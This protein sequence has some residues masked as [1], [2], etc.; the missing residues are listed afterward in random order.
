MKRNDSCFLGRGVEV[1]KLKDSVGIGTN[2]KKAVISEQL[3]EISMQIVLYVGDAREKVNQAL[4]YALDRNYQEAYKVFYSANKDIT[5]AFE[6]EK[7]EFVSEFQ[8]AQTRDGNFYEAVTNML[9][10]V[11]KDYQNVEKIIPFL[12]KSEQY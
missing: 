10:T 5:S 1:M 11:Q 12:E 3:N 6:L 2:M 7:T 4:D 9:M 8:Q